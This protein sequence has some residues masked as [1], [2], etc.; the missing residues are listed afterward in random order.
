MAGVIQRIMGG[1]K[2]ATT[3]FRE[4]YIHP[5]GPDGLDVVGS[6]GQSDAWSRFES[7]RM[8]Y[9]L[10]W[11]CYHNDQYRDLHNWSRKYRTD[12]GLYRNTRSIYGPFYRLAELHVGHI[13]GG[14]LDPMAGDGK[15]TPSA[16]P[17]T[18]TDERLRESVARLW[19]DSRWQSAKDLWVRWG[20]VLGDVAL[21]VE[22]DPERGQVTLNP[23]HP[24]SIQDVTLDKR[25]NVRGYCREEYRPHPITPR[26]NNGHVKYA[27]YREECTRETGEE[28]RY[29]TY[30]DGKPFAWNG[31]ASDW[32]M[33]YGFV[34]L[35]LTQHL[36]VGLDWGV[37]EA[38][39][40]MARTRE[41]DD[42]GSKLN[43]QV[44]K[45]VEAPWIIT[46]ATAK[47]ADFSGARNTAEGT[48]GGRE[49]D[50]EKS[51]ILFLKNEHARAQAMVAEV[52]IQEVSEHIGRIL[53]ETQQDY[54]ELRFDRMR[55]MGSISGQALREARKPA[56]Q[57]F[58]SRRSAYDDSIIRAH[59]MAIAIGGYRGYEG[60]Q[61]FNLDSYRAGA[62][63]HAIGNRSVYG[64]DPFEALEEEQLFWTVAAQA[65]SAGL[66]LAIY[67]AR[68][69]W[70]PEQ[71]AEITASAPPLGF[72]GTR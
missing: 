26:D 7:R 28:I 61:G 31:V 60:Y 29:R 8:R 59:Q 2:A 12:Y 30:L 23:V 37:S 53:D 56:E 15:A 36:N 34:P 38:N 1:L 3:A 50:R 11:A 57:K 18:T 4:A 33:P 10:Y 13:H 72:P 70:S 17:I 68:H 71:I 6:F 25:R 48:T 5:D 19:R 45:L 22:D 41:T 69:G 58:Q 43:D 62:L 54:P 14:P 44:R 39:A 66:P 9:S 27:L 65:Q 52:P 40:A 24:R 35:I 64:Y 47:D 55:G 42:V 63:D 51:L 16:L 67:L 20:T 46:G 21:A 49:T 32:T